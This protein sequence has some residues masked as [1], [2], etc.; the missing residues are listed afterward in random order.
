[1]K[2][3]TKVAVT[4]RAYRLDQPD[5]EKEYL[6]R[7]KYN[8]KKYY[9][10]DDDVHKYLNTLWDETK[11]SKKSIKT[12]CKSCIKNRIEFKKKLMENR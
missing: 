10:I 7:S 8:D 2:R 4:M 9:Y 1:M 11:P 6:M 5:V 3:I 12:P